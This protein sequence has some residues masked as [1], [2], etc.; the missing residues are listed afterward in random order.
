MIKDF[1]GI[2][3]KKVKSYATSYFFPQKIQAISILK[4][5]TNKVTIQLGNSLVNVHDY[6]GQLQEA[7][8]SW[9]DDDRVLTR[10]GSQHLREIRTHGRQHALKINKKRLAVHINNSV[11]QQK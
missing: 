6:A 5:K 10:I 1:L 3:F 8:I 7:H 11:K 9:H 4:S 2:T